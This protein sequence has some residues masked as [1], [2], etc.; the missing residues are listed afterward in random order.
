MVYIT[1]KLFLYKRSP[2]MKFSSPLYNPKIAKL[3]KIENT[4]PLT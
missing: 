3:L 2:L 4:A 1:E